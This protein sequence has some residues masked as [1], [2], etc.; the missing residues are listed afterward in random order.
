MNCKFKTLW[1]LTVLLA[2]LT[3]LSTGLAKKGGGGKPK[4]D[5][6][7][8][9]GARYHV[10][11]LSE[12]VDQVTNSGAVRSGRLLIEPARD[13]FDGKPIWDSD[14]DGVADG[15]TEFT[16]TLGGN[17]N[18]RVNSYNE[19]VG[20]A[21]GEAWDGDYWRAVI[22]TNIWDVNADGTFGTLVDLGS[23]NGAQSV[24][25]GDVNSKGQIVAREYS[26]PVPSAPWSMGL[27][28]VNPK[29][30]DG[31][32]EPDTWFEDGDG[33]GFND[34]MIDLEGTS[35]SGTSSDHLSI[36]NVGQIVGISNVMLGEGF[37]ILPEDG[38]WFKDDNS[39]GLNDLQVFL[40][41]GSRAKGISDGGSIVG[42]LTEGRK[43]Y[44]LMQW[45]IGQGQVGLV[46]KK[47]VRNWPQLIRTNNNAQVVA[48]IDNNNGISDAILWEN[49]EVLSLIELVD[50]PGDAGIIYPRSINDS[51]TIAGASC[52]YDSS[53][54]TTRC[55]EGF[56]AIPLALVD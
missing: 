48:L 49:G 23:Y 6:E 8:T 14:S 12:P 41:S 40:G 42:Y 47:S 7:P 10:I 2:L 30:V 5:P 37:V 13:D 3:F 20:A 25:P 31:D 4:P 11:L 51:G 46:A 24:I 29:D 17:V 55:Y 34:L 27:V 39:D 22:W 44:Y 32:G 52:Y 26:R 56:I 43:N 16:L 1:S 9:P 38:M 19:D 15:Y 45:E 21:V 18:A 35:M 33:D 53:E 36:N 50:N 28:L 54:K